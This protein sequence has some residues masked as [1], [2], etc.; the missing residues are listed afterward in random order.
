MAAALLGRTGHNRGF[1]QP[2]GT[3]SMGTRQACQDQE[4]RHTNMPKHCG[5]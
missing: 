4:H 1:S 3:Q 5:D 2:T